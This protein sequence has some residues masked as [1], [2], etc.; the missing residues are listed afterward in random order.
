MTEMPAEPIDFL[1]YEFVFKLHLTLEQNLTNLC[2]G[3]MDGV[4]PVSVVRTTLLASDPTDI[5]PIC[6]IF[7][8]S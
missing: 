7:I 5:A 8:K 1:S 6:I 3:P 2:L 4:R